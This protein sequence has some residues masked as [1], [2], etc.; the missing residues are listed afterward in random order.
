MFSTITRQLIAKHSMRGR[1]QLRRIRRQR[2]QADVLGYD[3]V[4]PRSMPAGTVECD[5]GMGAESHLGTDLGQVQVHPLPGRRLHGN[6]PKGA[7]MLT[8]GSTRAA[9]TPRA[10]QTAPKR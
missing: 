3:E 9:P 7:A 4:A 5:D 1:I 2:Q 10:G 6:L 8:P